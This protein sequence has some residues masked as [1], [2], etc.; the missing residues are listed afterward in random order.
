MLRV[1]QVLLK[2]PEVSETFL[3]AVP[4]YLDAEVTVVHSYIPHVGTAPVLSGR[5]IDR[6]WRRARRAL[7]RLPWDHEITLGYITA[8]RRAD[9]EVALAE[10]GPAGVRVREACTQTGIPLVVRFHGYDGYSRGAIERHADGY[11]Q[12]FSSASAFVAP[13]RAMVTQLE[14]L[15]APPDRIHW[16][17]N[18]ADCSLFGGASPAQAPPIVVAVGR[19]VEKKAPQLTIRAFREAARGL[20]DARLHF[21]G[22]GGLLDTCRQLAITLGIERQVVFLGAQPP[23]VVQKELRSARVFVQHSVVASDGDSETFPISILE[24]GAT[25]LPVVATRHA[26]IPDMVRDRTDGY[27]VD[28]RDVDGMSDGLRRLLESADLAQRM[29]TAFQARVRQEFSIQR[30]MS[31][32]LRVLE[33]VSS[34]GRSLR[35]EGKL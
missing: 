10:F 13:S 14:R 9:A 11:R 29:G 22:E 4:Q 32:L 18:G 23:E 8:L 34:A 21:I 7:A 25:G 20:P 15:G 1:C 5:L 35:A 16:V 28:E 26:G 17:P 30:T 12:L 24:A 31:G 3:V 19:F 2:P 6:A 33:A 27:L